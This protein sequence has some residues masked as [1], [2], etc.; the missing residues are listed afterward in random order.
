M[1]LLLGTLTLLA[2]FAVLATMVWVSRAVQRARQE[3]GARQIALTE[4]IHHS[5]G[6]V[7]APSVRPALRGRWRV[8]IPVPF[9]RPDIVGAV[10]GIAHRTLRDPR[11]RIVVTAQEAPT[12]CR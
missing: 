12:P 10:L 9:H 2:P 1:T 4:A 5:L 11:S 7:V 3:A 8:T 6:A